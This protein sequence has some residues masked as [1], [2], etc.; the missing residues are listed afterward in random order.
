MTF[1]WKN[2]A[3]FLLTLGVLVLC[4]LMLHV[5]LAAIV[6]AI[7][8]AVAT[9]RPFRWLRGKLHNA[10]GAAA[11]AL[12]IT[13][14]CVIVPGT[15]LGRVVAQYAFTIGR[16]LRNG[17]VEKSIFAVVDQHP[18]LNSIIQ[19]SSR[20]LNWNKTAERAGAYIATN[21]V[22]LLS[23]SAVALTQ[24]IVMLFL[25][26]FLYRDGDTALRFLYSVL[27][28]EE[29]EAHTLVKGVEGTIRAT[30]LGHFFVA[31]IQGLAA[32]IVFAI[33]GVGDAAL[34]GVLTAIA[35]ILPYF[36]AYIVWAPVAIY[37]GLSGH[38]LK[39]AILV[40]VGT[41]AI[42]TLD[43]VLYPMLVGAQLRQ[44]TA[45]IFLAFL[46]GIW[47]FGIPGLVL[48]PVIFSMASS[49]LSIWHARN[50]AQKLTNAT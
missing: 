10:T 21:V 26:F 1:T 34:L 43:N 45:V 11:I 15:F 2:V 33:L 3:L 42:S 32:G 38:L 20:F 41:L 6:G 27:P 47:L 8:L 13:T 49:S 46:G 28:M 5:F 40:V 36:G 29:S 4:M 31:S 44:H 12:S 39:G 7:V 25:L 48:G 37:L 9:E 50:H 17:T 14:L 18:W 23:N 24:T 30:F 35:A 22:T 16:M 19:E